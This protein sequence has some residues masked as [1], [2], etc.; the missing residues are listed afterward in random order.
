[1][2]QPLDHVCYMTDHNENVT[3]HDKLS[4][5]DQLIAENKKRFNQAA[6]SPFLQSL[7]VDL[8]G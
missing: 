4:M 7:L 5:E 1:M 3:T 6:Q 8:V 2:Y